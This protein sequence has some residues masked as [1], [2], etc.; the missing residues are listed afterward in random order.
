MWLRTA[1]VVDDVDPEGWRGGCRGTVTNFTP[2]VFCASILFAEFPSCCCW[3][4]GV[5]VD[6]LS[7]RHQG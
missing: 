4:R 3:R 1:D 5:T 6:L 7:R 2:T